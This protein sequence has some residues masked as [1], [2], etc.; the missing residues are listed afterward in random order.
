MVGLDTNILVRYFARDDA[1]QLRKVRALMQRLSP[2]NPGYISHITLVEL[3]WVMRTVYGAT[4][5]RIA[6][7]VE[8]LLNAT[9]LRF[10][11][12][13]LVTLAWNAYC[14]GKAD[15]ADY[16]MELSHRAAGCTH[17]VTFDR[18][19]AQSTGMKLL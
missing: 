14:A 15:F 2:E 16:L 11:N 6:N 4:R 13:T 9:D 12:E 7:V 3:I 19:A 1:A 17:T 8:S 10:E 18:L 5:A